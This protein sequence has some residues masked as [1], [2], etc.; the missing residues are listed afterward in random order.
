MAACTKVRA[1]PDDEDKKDDETTSEEEDRDSSEESESKD[2]GDEKGSE[3]DEDADDK[4]S[5]EKSD[6]GEDDTADEEE[7][8]DAEEEEEEDAASPEAIARRVAA[9]GDDD[10]EIA[11]IA[12]AEEAKLAERKSKRK[13]K[14]GGLEKAASK[15][16]A[17]IGTKSRPQR[18]VASAIEAAE[19]SIERAMRAEDWA[20]K[21][22]K[23]VWGV[24]GAI[25]VCALGWFGWAYIDRQKSVEASV[26]LAQAVA[27]ENARI[28]D[29]AK[30]DP[31]KPTDPSPSFKTYDERREAALAKYKEVSS[32]YPS[33]GAAT[34]ARLGEAA[35][36]LD[37]RDT[38]GAVTAFNDA[39]NSP[40]AKA[41]AE[42][43][44]RALEGLGFAYE[45]KAQTTPADKD[46]DLD[47][48]LTEFKALENTDVV[49]FKELGMYHQGRVY[50]A[51]G[52]IAKAKETLKA[53]HDRLNEPGQN[54]PLP[55]L[56]EL[57]DDRLRRIDPT[58]LPAKEQGMLGGPTGKGLTPAQMKQIFSPKP[59]QQ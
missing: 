52:D 14:R 56:Q 32:K 39:K 15:R 31:D 46:K 50:Q 20:K 58:A 12:E 13:G 43:M 57:C 25:V 3:S 49:G 6:E 2:E 5:E 9:L 19:P 10:D 51:K 30:D 53:L 33:T 23:T 55:Y 48:A 41:D 59:G 27:N 1:V 34:L 7:D 35:L 8:E 40:L 38:D 26:A 45:Q 21:N 29:P 16:L 4:S 44:G 54:H 28:G 42:V 24:V 11:K 36:L 22:Q 18:E 37:K 47:E 17:K